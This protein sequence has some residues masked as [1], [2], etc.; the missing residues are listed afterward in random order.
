MAVAVFD[1]PPIGPSTVSS[2]A[3]VGI[4]T[5]D[6]SAKSFWDQSNIARAAFT[7]RIDIFSIDMLARYVRYDFYQYHK[8]RPKQ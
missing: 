4:E 6:L 2:R 8:R 7:C 5:P 1:R 3:I